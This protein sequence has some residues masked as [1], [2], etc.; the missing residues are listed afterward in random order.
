MITVCVKCEL[1][2]TATINEQFYNGNREGC[3]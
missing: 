3:H 2:A 1:T